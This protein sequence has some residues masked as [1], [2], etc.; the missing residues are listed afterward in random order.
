[1]FI[2]ALF[3]TPLCLFDRRAYTL[4]TH[5]CTCFSIL[6]PN[7]YI[8][9]FLH[10]ISLLSPPVK[11]EEQRIQRIADERVHSAEANFQTRT[12][13]VTDECWLDLAKV[14]NLSRGKSKEAVVEMHN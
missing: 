7:L 9:F 2:H 11:N 5:A 4:V 8:P 1:M 6:L 14:H 13:E 3:F 10:L 12:L